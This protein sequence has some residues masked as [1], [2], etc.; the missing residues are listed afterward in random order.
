MASKR[1]YN[2]QSFMMVAESFAGTYGISARW[3]EVDEVAVIGVFDLKNNFLG[4]IIP[5]LFQPFSHE[6]LAHLKG[7][8]YH[9]S[10]QAQ[11]SQAKEA[12]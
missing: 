10:E 2:D 12:Q 7:R 6:T 4:T 1:W 11:Q 3:I 5:D 8:L 9:L